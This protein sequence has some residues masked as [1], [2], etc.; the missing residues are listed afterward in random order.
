MLLSVGEGR[1]ATTKQAGETD[2]LWIDIP[3][4]LLLKPSEDKFFSITDVVYDDFE[5]N[6]ALPSYLAQRA[7]ICPVN[8]IVDEVSDQMLMRIPTLSKEYLSY[9]TIAN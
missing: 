7:T 3:P 9:D 8:V 6:H 1:L 5:V 2:P 4:E